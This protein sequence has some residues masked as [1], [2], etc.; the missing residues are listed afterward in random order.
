MARMAGIGRDPN[1]KDDTIAD[2][3]IIATFKHG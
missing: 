2:G 3:E 1:A